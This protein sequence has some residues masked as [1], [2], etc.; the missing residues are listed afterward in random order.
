M[1]AIPTVP[2]SRYGNLTVKS[3]AEPEPAK[4]RTWRRWLLVCDCGTEMTKRV[5]EVSAGRI[6]SCMACFRARQIRHGEARNGLQS[7]EY[8]VWCGMMRRCYTP[9]NQGY[10]WYGARGI[11]VAERW[12]KYENF[13]S[14][15]GRRPS[16]DMHI[17]RINPKGDYEPGNCR[18]VTRTENARNRSNNVIISFRG[19]SGCVSEFIESSGLHR[20]LVYRRLREGWSPDEALLTPSGS[21]KGG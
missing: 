3:D 7:K 17:D 21:P 19:K 10:K 4:G 20:N 8:F 9:Q 6:S 14:D 12:H 16:P 18:W 13:L 2:G 5:N 11:R 1:K 15:M